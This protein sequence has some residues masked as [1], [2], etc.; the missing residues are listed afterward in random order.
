MLK[1]FWLWLVLSSSDP[2]KYSLTIKSALTGVITALT[3]VAGLTNITL[4][5]PD[6]TAIVDNIVATVQ[7]I[8]LLVSLVTGTYGFIMKVWDTINGTN[9]VIN[10]HPAFQQ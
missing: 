10:E 3:I 6:L 4:S 1:K 2:T 5:T 7:T 8:L 9:A